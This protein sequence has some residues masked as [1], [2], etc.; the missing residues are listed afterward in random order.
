MP[1]RLALIFLAF[2]LL[3]APSPAGARDQR[4]PVRLFRVGASPQYAGLA[5]LGTARCRRSLE[6]GFDVTGVLASVP[7]EE[8]QTVKKGQLLARLD[9]SV[10]RA[11]LKAA[12]ADL[13]KAE[14]EAAYRQKVE[15]E[16]KALLAGRAVSRNEYDKARFEARQAKAALELSRAQVAGKKARIK[17]MT[18]TAPVAGVVAARLAEPGEVVAPGSDHFK[19]V[20]LVS[21]QTVLAEVDFS[22]S[23]YTRLA[24]GLLVVVTAD[25]LGR[26]EFLGRVH[27]ISPEINEKD[28]TVRVKVL[29]H[30]PDFL[31]RP[32][33]FVR[34]AVL[35]PPD[36][37]LWVPEQAILAR[38]GD[39]AV[40][41]VVQ[42]KARVKRR[43]ELGEA[44][45]GMLRVKEG[46]K[47]GELVLVPGPAGPA[48]EDGGRS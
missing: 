38:K 39:A 17:A 34:A 32:G 43:I 16:Q 44:K 5:G 11:D 40:V 29:L 19:V 35:G 37:E 7:V 3:L 12:Q 27:T 31:L 30:N 8:G 47:P 13:A 48:P 20:R 14:V 2:C 33:M 22:E 45:G 25:A 18:L 26:R 9:D 1:Q 23:N 46:L 4:G 15:A 24:P 36:V 41:E 42:G 10:A 28:R 21:C 6:L